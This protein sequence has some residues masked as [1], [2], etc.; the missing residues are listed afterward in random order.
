M[1]MGPLRERTT[2]T[3][4][5]KPATALLALLVFLAVA[6]VARPTMSAEADA[7]HDINRIA[8]ITP[9]E[10]LLVQPLAISK[11]GQLLFR[12]YGIKIG[13]LQG[14]LDP[15]PDSFELEYL[16][17]PGTLINVQLFNCP[18]DGQY[19]NF[20]TVHLPET[21]G[22]RSFDLKD[23]QSKL[24]IRT[25]ADGNS[26]ALE[27]EFIQGDLFI[28]ADRLPFED[29]LRLLDASRTTVEFGD[30]NDRIQFIVE[31]QFGKARIKD[32]MR[33]VLPERM[34]WDVKTLR[35]FN[36]REMIAACLDFRRNGSMPKFQER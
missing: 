31:D 18:R 15:K 30:K 7:K 13:N 34:N 23:W 17:P 19:A 26:R 4:L 3:N 22:L 11:D 27:G 36:T 28:G 25:L 35:Y 5:W 33:D 2:N 24:Q 29:F 10:W 1:T 21:V 32:F 12:R 20:L 9:K 14:D 6:S 8:F 16:D